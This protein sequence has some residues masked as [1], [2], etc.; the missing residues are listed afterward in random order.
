MNV[1]EIKKIKDSLV[2]VTAGPWI[3]LI[4]DR[5]HTSGSS[6]I[7][8]GDEEYDINFY[9]LRPADQDFIAMSRNV[10]P[11]LLDE[12]IRLRKILSE[13]NISS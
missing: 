4:E 8:T 10:L 5:D 2:S 3:S 13:N 7:Q 12:V 9:G 11:L 6:F 1:D